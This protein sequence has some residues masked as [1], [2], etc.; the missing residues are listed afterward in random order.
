[1]YLRKRSIV[2]LYYIL[3]PLFFLIFMVQ[4]TKS[5]ADTETLIT[6][7]VVKYSNPNEGIP[8]IEVTAYII[9]PITGIP[10]VTADT[11]PNG[12]Y[13]IQVDALLTSTYDE[14]D[15]YVCAEDPNNV[16]VR[17]C[18]E[19]YYYGAIEYSNLEELEE[20]VTLFHVKLNN[21]PYSG[22]NFRF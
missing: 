21:P 20:E 15:F 19:G 6:G 17:E 22:K 5:F 13:T 16:Y 12:Y 2:Q 1:M 8:N 7:R 10:S 4:T 11:D 18:Y 3:I 14:Q 9:Q